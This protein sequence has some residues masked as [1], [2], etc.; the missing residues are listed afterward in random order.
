M[1][2]PARGRPALHRLVDLLL[3][4]PAVRDTIAAEE[5]AAPFL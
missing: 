1:A 2:K 3:E 4:R 5:L